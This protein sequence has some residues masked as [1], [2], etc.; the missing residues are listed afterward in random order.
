MLH[1][2][3]PLVHSP[4]LS[5]EGRSV[6][7]K[8]D[9]DQPAGSF[10]IRGIGALCEQQAALGVRGFVSSS[11]GNAGLAVA[12]AGTRLSLP[13]TIV[14]PSTTSESVRQRMRDLNADVFE[15]GEVWDESDVHARKIAKK[16]RMAYV[17]PFDDPVIWQGH[18][19]LVDELVVQGPKP[20]VLICSVGGGGLL[21]GV[22]EGLERNGWADVSVLAVETHGA[23]SLRASVDAGELVTIPAITSIAKTLGAKRVARRALE[24]TQSHGVRCVQ[25]SDLEA[26]EACIAFHREQDVFVEPSCGAALAAVSTRHPLL[27]SAQEISVVVCGGNGVDSMML[28]RWKKRL[29]VGSE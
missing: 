28:K 20:D 23:A 27:Q 5:G 8:M 22:M 21:C 17:H 6:Y 19:T 29:E 13:C 12:Y 3:T 25:V 11:G 7:L 15:F 10:K 16:K 18:A 26:V 24:W 14:V 1:K 4:T 2:K 9:C